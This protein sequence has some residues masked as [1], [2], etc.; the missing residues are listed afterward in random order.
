MIELPISIQKAAA[1]YK[2]IEKYG[3]KLY[4]VLVKDY[5][6]FLTAR[7]A[8][9]VMHQSLPLALMR[10]PLLAA[11]YQMDFEAI[12]NGETPSGLFSRAI[13]ALALSLR[14]GEGLE[15]EERLQLFR[16][17]LNRDDP[18]QLERVEYSDES[19]E[20]KSILPAQF[21]EIRLIIAAQNGVEIE[22]EQANPDL[23]QAEKDM[24][25]ANAIKL[26][27][28]VE[29]WISA[30]SAL[31]GADEDEIDEWPILKLQRRSEAYRRILDYL[32]CGFGEVNGTTWKGGNPTPHP[33]FPRAARGLGGLVP[34][35]SLNS[36][37]IAAAQQGAEN[38]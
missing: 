17:A 11:L 5:E 2:T 21:A 15:L 26:E 10:M 8:I 34:L 4:P 16:V 18:S 27:A 1:R 25:E 32:V 22:S 13:L 14:L 20:K 33:F 3:L 19:G 31:S 36:G 37:S 23:V 24:A 38:N 30:I 35:S 28:S 9:E 6:L 12:R 7:P 29:T